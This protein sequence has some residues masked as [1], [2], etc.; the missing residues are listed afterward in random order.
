MK[1]IITSLVV[2]VVI[3]FGGLIFLQKVNFNRLGADEYY[4]QINDQGKKV[5]S[6]A[7]NGEK[8]VQYE[9]T[10]LAFDKDGKQKT[11]SFSAQ[12]QLRE[13][14]YLRLYVK[15]KKGV[16]SFQ[17]VKKEELPQKVREKLK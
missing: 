9:Y 11:F 4:V 3:I 13:N 15:N 1:K 17:E 16:T 8:Y 5:E 2:I 6:K 12:K 14:A 7:D 10:L